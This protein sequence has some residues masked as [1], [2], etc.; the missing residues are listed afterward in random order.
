MEGISSYNNERSKISAGPFSDRDSISGFVG[1]NVRDVPDVA[2]KINTNFRVDFWSQI[3]KGEDNQIR[4]GIPD[5]IN[6]DK[7][8]SYYDNV[9]EPSYQRNSVMSTQ[10]T[11][12]NVHNNISANVSKIDPENVSQITGL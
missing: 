5:N 10:L 9:W 4:D 3:V 7:L 6:R 12:V 11:H 2:N 1:P 8:K